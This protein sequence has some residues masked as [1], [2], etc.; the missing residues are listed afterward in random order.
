MEYCGP[1]WLGLKFRFPLIWW[2]DKNYKGTYRMKKKVEREYWGA[3]IMSNGFSQLGDVPEYSFNLT[4]FYRRILK[5][6]PRERLIE[7]QVLNHSWVREDD[8][9]PDIAIDKSVL[10]RMNKFRAMNKL[11]K[12]TLNIIVECL[13]NSS[14]V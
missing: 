1:R 11:K 2:P 8:E 14:F 4:D 13:L 6:D 3:L 12:F 5:F 7:I 9:A 10:N